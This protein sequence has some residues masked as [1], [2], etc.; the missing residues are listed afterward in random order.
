MFPVLYNNVKRIVQTEDHIMILNE[1]V[2][3]A[4]IIRLNAEHLPDEIRKWNGDSIGHWE[5]RTLVVDTTNFNNRSGLGLASRQLHVVEKFKK[6]DQPSRIIFTFNPKA[7]WN[8]MSY[9]QPGMGIKD[10]MTFIQLRKWNR[11]TLNALLSYYQ[12]ID[13]LE[14]S[15]KLL[16]FSH[17]WY[18]T[19]YNLGL[20]KNGDQTNFLQICSKYNISNLKKSQAQR[21]INESGVES[22]PWVKPLINNLIE[23][24]DQGLDEEIIGLVLD[25]L[26]S[27]HDISMKDTK[28]VIDWLTQ[29]SIFEEKVSKDKTTYYIID[30]IIIQYLNV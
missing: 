19:P 10:N 16:K 23:Y 5:G 27:E 4:R 6:M 24:K 8:W 17:G 1:M 14:E 12:L 20:H 9:G 25:D 11:P 7:L 13:T 29:I 28:Q 3:D 26:P 30:E 21:F 22:L 2:H 15:K 18:H